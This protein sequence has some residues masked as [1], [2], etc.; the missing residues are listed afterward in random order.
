MPKRN[1]AFKP[2]TDDKLDLLATITPQDE[3]AAKV[4]YRELA[5]RKERDRVYVSLLDA[6]DSD[7]DE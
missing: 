7:L 1:L 3:E 2:P 4:R 5:K 6:K